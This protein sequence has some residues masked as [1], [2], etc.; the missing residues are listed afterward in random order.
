MAS[1]I[2]MATDARD[3]AMELRGGTHPDFVARY[4]RDP[5]SHWPRL[6]AAEARMIS[7]AGMKLVTVWESH[8]GR[9][10]YF[11]YASGYYDAEA[12]YAQAKAIG[13]PPG[14]AIYFAVDF[15]AQEPDVLWRIDPYFRGIAAGL[16]A[17]A[18][19]HISEYRIGIYGSGLVCD[20]L[21][22]THLA[23]YA[24]LS[25]ARAWSGYASFDDWDIRQGGRSPYLS[26]SQDSNEARG[27][28]GGFRVENQYSAL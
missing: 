5:A 15:N 23:Q 12:A 1:G 27:D 6:S 17:A 19:R 22:R 10:D 14:S 11:T 26:F 25:N 24:W 21:K 16:A 18:P 13:Q 4:Y 2:D 28:Y 9:P 20:Y 3:V 7:N 8:S